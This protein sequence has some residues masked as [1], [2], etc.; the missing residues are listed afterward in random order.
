M[1]LISSTFF[2]RIFYTKVT[3]WQLFLVACTLKKL[4]K[5]IFVRK[6][7]TFNVDEID[8]WIPE[9]INSPFFFA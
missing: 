9:K 4:P 2:A 3:F 1:P 6:T 8:P 7:H 5:Q